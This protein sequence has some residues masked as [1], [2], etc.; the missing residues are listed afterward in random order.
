MAYADVVPDQTLGLLPGEVEVLLGRGDGTFRPRTTYAVGGS[1]EYVDAGDLDH[2]GRLDLVVANAIFNN[3]IS[4]LYGRAG[5][6]FAREQ[7]ISAPGMGLVR[8]A[9]AGT[10]GDPGVQVADFDRDGHLDIAV[11]QTVAGKVIVLRGDGRRHFTAAREYP[12]A[13]LP[14]SFLATDLT[15]DGFPD[16]AVPGNAPALGGTSG[17]LATR[18]AVLVNRGR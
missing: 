2:D 12:A 9:G 10:D 3:D 5:G 15:G 11:I 17:V 4:V 16:L 18:V 6:K 8:L 14:E 7:R 13:L 1:P